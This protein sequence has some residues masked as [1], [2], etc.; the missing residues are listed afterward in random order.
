MVSLSTLRGSL[1][2]I[3]WLIRAFNLGGCDID[4]LTRVLSWFG[5]TETLS[6]RV[7]PPIPINTMYTFLTNEKPLNSLSVQFPP[8]RVPVPDPITVSVI[9]TSFAVH[10][11]S[12]ICL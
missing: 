11:L 10:P 2:T 6:R 4:V 12:S 9:P 5:T 7:F 8:I 3:V 1:G